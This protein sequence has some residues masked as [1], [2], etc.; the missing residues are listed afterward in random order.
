MLVERYIVIFHKK[1]IF[2]PSSSH[3]PTISSHHPIPESSY[4]VP[5]HVVRFFE[6][7]TLAHLW[8]RS[9]G[10]ELISFA[11]ALSAVTFSPRVMP[12]WNGC[13][14]RARELLPYIIS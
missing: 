3:H 9:G 8:V 12:S 11:A 1:K 6:K 5:I 14:S 10:T 7:L 4:A 2:I 13:S